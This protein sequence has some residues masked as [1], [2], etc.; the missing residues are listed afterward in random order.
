MDP[1]GYRQ[2]ARPSLCVFILK[3]LNTV[4]LACEATLSLAHPNPSPLVYEHEDPGAIAGS[5]RLEESLSACEGLVIE[6]RWCCSTHPGIGHTIVLGVWWNGTDIIVCILM[7]SRLCC[8][9]GN[10]CGLPV[11]SQIFTKNG[12]PWGTGWCCFVCVLAPPFW[13]SFRSL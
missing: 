10:V 4:G 6:C 13:P 3:K 8:V 5:V 7:L 9:S 2:W 11:V 12:C 1:N